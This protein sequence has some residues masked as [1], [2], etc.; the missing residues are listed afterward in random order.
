MLGWQVGIPEGQGAM[1]QE[2]MTSKISRRGLFYEG[3]LGKL[4]PE[5]SRE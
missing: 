5:H 3:W 1:K 2:T 4:L